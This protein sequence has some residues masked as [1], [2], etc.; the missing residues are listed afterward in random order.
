M[1]FYGIVAYGIAALWLMADFGRRVAG[2]ST[3]TG[4]SL[5]VGRSVSPPA[6]PRG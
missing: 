6:H 4:P 3:P 5:A 1:F 2:E